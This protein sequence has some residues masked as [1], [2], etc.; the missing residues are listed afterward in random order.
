MK[1]ERLKV[2]GVRVTGNTL[3]VSGA[4]GDPRW[5]LDYFWT[6]DGWDAG[7]TAAALTLYDMAKAADKSIVIGPIQLEAKSGGQSGSYQRPDAARPAEA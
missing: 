6:V 7:V 1:R 4:G 3:H 5:F 2:S